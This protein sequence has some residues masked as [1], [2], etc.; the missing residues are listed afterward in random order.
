[1]SLKTATLASS[2]LLC[3]AALTGCSS[4]EPGRKPA[5]E[6]SEPTGRAPPVAD[7]GH[8]PVAVVAC[9]S[10]QGLAV[11][12]GLVWVACTAEDEVP[13]YLLGD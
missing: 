13:L 7:P 8:R 5:A 9:T 1:M 10:P 4:S 11:T 2:F 3:A 12:A 6:P